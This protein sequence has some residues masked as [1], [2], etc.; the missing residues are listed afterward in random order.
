VRDRENER[1]ANV[2]SGKP[3][4]VTRDGRV[5]V[6]SRDIALHF[7]KDHRNVL[8]VIR[9]LDIPPDLAAK[10]FVPSIAPDSYGR[11]QVIFEMTRDGFSLVAMSYT[12]ARAMQYKIAYVAE[13]NRLETELKGIDKT[14][15]MTPVP[16]PFA[17]VP[18][19]P[20]AVAGALPVVSGPDA[21][22]APASAA[23]DV[24]PFSFDGA[25]VRVITRDAISEQ[26]CERLAR[27]FLRLKRRL[28]FSVN[29][30][31]IP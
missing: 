10:F 12:G 6:S 18:G 31:L 16:R 27:G 19:A 30:L 17:E 8:R 14:L 23:G 25:T 7:E 9:A 1:K 28:G 3:K 26:N 21:V 20:P 2:P 4:L 5:L 22:A 11:P 15:E 29:H 24:V 13:F